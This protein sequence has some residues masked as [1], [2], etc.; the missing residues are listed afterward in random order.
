MSILIKGMQ[1]LGDSIYQRI[2][3]R[4]T[5]S[6]ASI[7]IETSWPELYGDLPVRFV[8]R[9]VGLRTQHRNIERQAPERWSSPP[10]G[11]R[12]VRV[13]Y[14]SRDLARGSNVAAM[15]RCLPLRGSPFV[16]DLPPLPPP[17]VTSTRPVAVVRPVTVRSEWRNEA[18]NP[19]PEHVAQIADRLMATHHVVS[20]ADLEAGA[21]WLLDPAPPAHAV[22][23]R[24][25]LDVPQLLALVASSSL[26]VGGVGWIVPAA[27]AAR[28]PVFIVLGGQGGHNA[29]EKITDRRMDLSRIGW[30]VPPAFCR[31][32][33]MMHKGCDKR[34]PDLMDQFGGWHEAMLPGLRP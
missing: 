7:W 4:A 32:A 17:P 29:P 3:V 2:F 21:E 15:E 10:P 8:R 18:R 20:V 28:V 24:G 25:E 30:G 33:D 5:A 13:S 11:A 6:R 23:H 27:I 1:G 34:I 12:H 19:L 16:M 14:G 31:C 9:E 26:V 22:M